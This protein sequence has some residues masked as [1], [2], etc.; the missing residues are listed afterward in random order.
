M[1][2]VF[3]SLSDEPAIHQL[4]WLAPLSVRIGTLWLIAARVNGIS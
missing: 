2:P 1:L 3:I 4:P